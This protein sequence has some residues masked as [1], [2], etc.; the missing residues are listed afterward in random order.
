VSELQPTEPLLPHHLAVLSAVREAGRTGAN[1]TKLARSAAAE[2]SDDDYE[3][4]VTE[5]VDKEL[6][7]AS[8][9]GRGAAAAH[10]PTGITAKGREAL[11]EPE[12]AS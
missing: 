6:I 3:D 12:T 2:L 4:L 10:Y 8:K 7:M 5:L 11:T 1:P 9:G